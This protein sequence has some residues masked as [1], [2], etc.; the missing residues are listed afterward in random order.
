MGYWTT[1]QMAEVRR[2]QSRVAIALKAACDEAEIVIPYP[3]R[4][5]HFYDREQFNESKHKKAHNNDQVE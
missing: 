1:P 2:I 4:T 5:V 3:I